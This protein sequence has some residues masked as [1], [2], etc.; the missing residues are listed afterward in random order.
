MR[1]RGQRVNERVRTE[2]EDRGWVR[3]RGQRVSER[4]RTEGE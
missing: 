4:A 2:G 3:G 1:G